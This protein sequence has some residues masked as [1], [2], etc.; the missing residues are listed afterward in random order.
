VTH[1][2]Q[3]AENRAACPGDGGGTGVDTAENGLA[4][5]GQFFG[6]CPEDAD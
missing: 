4:P 2:E 3:E 6:L 5:Y 1:G